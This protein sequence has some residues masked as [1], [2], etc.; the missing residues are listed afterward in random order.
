M[1]PQAPATYALRRSA[2]SVRPPLARAPRERRHETAG[3]AARRKSLSGA[4]SGH[5]ALTRFP[6]VRAHARCRFSAKAAGPRRVNELPADRSDRSRAL[7]TDHHRM[8]SAAVGGAR[9]TRK[10]RRLQRLRLCEEGGLGELSLHSKPLRARRLR[11]RRA[12][13]STRVETVNAAAP[14]IS[15]LTMSVPS[16]IVRVSRLDPP[17][18]RAAG[19]NQNCSRD[20]RCLERS[21]IEP[22]GAPCKRRTRVRHAASKAQAAQKPPVHL[23]AS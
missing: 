3:Q 15:P 8:Q 9:G 14:I 17:G 11:R 7:G 6:E 22:N 2:T 21:T 20:H 16:K 4:S 19:G 18:P 23:A 13:R 1:Q 12:H 5:A 10:R